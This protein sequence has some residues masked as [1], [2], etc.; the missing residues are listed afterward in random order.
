MTEN[1]W[2]DLV[3]VK[4]LDNNQLEVLPHGDEHPQIID[5]E[6]I[7]VIVAKECFGFTITYK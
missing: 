5:G 3:H 4:V 1:K 2:T 6:L 7:D